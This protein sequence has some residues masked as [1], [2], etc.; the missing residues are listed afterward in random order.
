MGRIIQIA[1][2]AKWYDLVALDDLGVVYVGEVRRDGD[3]VKVIWQ[4]AESEE[5]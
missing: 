2:A 4:V 5:R 3:T 1:A